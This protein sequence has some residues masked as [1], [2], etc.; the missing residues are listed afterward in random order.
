MNIS[1]SSTT[2]ISDNFAF[3][4]TLTF[5]FYCFQCQFFASIFTVPS[6]H[7]L[8]AYDIKFLS[9]R[10]PLRPKFVAQEEKFIR[11]REDLNQS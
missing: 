5:S 11:P 8:H 1:Q 10:Q 7:A 9:S 6:D 4:L 3:S 2:T